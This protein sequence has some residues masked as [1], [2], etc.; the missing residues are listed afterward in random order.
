MFDNRGDKAS[1]KAPDFRCRVETCTDPATGR[2]TALW[3][4]DLVKKGQ[5]QPPAPP[6]PVTASNAPAAPADSVDR[7]TQGSRMHYRCLQFVLKHELPLIAQ[8]PATATLFIESNRTNGK[9]GA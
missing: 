6:V 7:L 3:A 9:H 4:R 2:R 5:Q 8:L 1:A